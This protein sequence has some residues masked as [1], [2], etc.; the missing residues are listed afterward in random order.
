MYT[1]YTEPLNLTG[2]QCNLLN[3]GQAELID[4]VVVPIAP[5]K[6]VIPNRELNVMLRRA[7][8][9]QITDKVKVEVSDVKR[10]APIVRRE[11]MGKFCGK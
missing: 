6:K 2:K 10:T 5:T 7:K 3:T 9:T 8:A 4:N 11:Y 1:P